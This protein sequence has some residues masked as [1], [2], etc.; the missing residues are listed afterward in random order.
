MLDETFSTIASHFMQYVLMKFG[1]CRLV[2]LDDGTPFN[3]YFVAICQ[4]L[5]L[6]YDIL[7][8]RNHKGLSVE[9]FHH[10][11]YTNGIIVAE[12]RNTIDIFV[13]TGIVAWYAWNSALIDG[14]DIRRSNSAIG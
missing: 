14:N 9:S 7:A 6:N 12:E 1:L 4:D 3:G 2:V 5:N 13:P 10:F 11:L 8:K